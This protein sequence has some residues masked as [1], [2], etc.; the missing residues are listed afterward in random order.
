MDTL[1]KDNAMPDLVTY[2]NLPTG[3]VIHRSVGPVDDGGGGGGVIC[4]AYIRNA[5]STQ[6]YG[7]DYS[8]P[9]ADQNRMTNAA[10]WGP[11]GSIEACQPDMM[12]QV[13][14]ELAAN[15]TDGTSAWLV[16]P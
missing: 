14:N 7:A 4:G 16:L 10:Y 13:V 6:W 3:L 5:D 8:G 2:Q 9:L 1:T 12:T 15:G 11:A